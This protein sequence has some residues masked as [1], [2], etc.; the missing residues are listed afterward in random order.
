MLRAYA[1]DALGNWSQTDIPVTVG[2]SA[3]TLR[4]TSISLSG[5]VRRYAA[6]ITGIVTVKDSLNQS[7]PG[8][9]VS[10]RWTLP[11][12]GTQ[13][14]AA[15]T[16]SNGRARFSVTSSRGTYTLNILNVVK[17]GY[18]FD[19]ANSILTKSITK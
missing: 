19:A 2:E 3:N 11:S 9:A 15:V 10:A 4:V 18:T 13:A 6:T 8:A 12:G 1:Y 7:V 5:T 17:T 16:G 14:A